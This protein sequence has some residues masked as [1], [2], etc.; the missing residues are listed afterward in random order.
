MKTWNQKDAIDFCINAENY[1][2]PKGYHVA[3]TGGTLYKEGERK[4][5]DLFIYNNDNFEHYLPLNVSY[6]QGLGLKLTDT[7]TESKRT[8]TVQ[9]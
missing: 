6:L 1:L 2:R 9:D 4:D 5:L 8:M 3:L 7:N